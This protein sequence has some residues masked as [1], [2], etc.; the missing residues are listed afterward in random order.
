MLA[1]FFQIVFWLCLAFGIFALVMA[2][3]E[4]RS[5]ADRGN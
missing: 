2:R 4:R 3:Y 1:D 5:G